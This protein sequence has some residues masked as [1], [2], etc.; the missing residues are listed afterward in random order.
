MKRRFLLMLIVCLMQT[1][2]TW[3]QD[4]VFLGRFNNTELDLVL[5]MNLYEET[6]KIPGQDILG[7]VYGYVKKNTD[8]RVWII[9][10]VKF[11]DDKKTAELDIINDY[12]SEDLKASISYD[13]DGGYTLRQLEGSTMKVA[14]KGKWVKLPKVM[15]F[16]NKAIIQR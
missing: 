15:R 3:A 9:M 6:I 7:E 12:G 8:S 2:G 1:A 5:D 14:V 13:A 11:A 4:K 16:F 10:G